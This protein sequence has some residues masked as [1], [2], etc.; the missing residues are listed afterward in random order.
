MAISEALAAAGRPAKTTNVA[1]LP[2]P[3]T[4]RW[5][6]RN[7]N[8]RSASAQFKQVGHP[9]ERQVFSERQGNLAA[10]V[11]AGLQ[12]R[13][14]P[15]VSMNP[16]HRTVLFKRSRKRAVRNTNRQPEDAHLHCTP[17]AVND[18]AASTFNNE[19]SAVKN[20]G[21]RAV[22]YKCNHLY[23]T[24]LERA[25]RDDILDINDGA[26]GITEVFRG[27]RSSNG[28]SM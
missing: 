28:V 13:A 17:L 2:A 9:L 11:F 4:E 15:P 5:A 3:K 23:M 21:G 22:R 20:T 14:A 7:D 12:F 24:H 16:L 8:E 19:V 25:K 26:E 1:N 6:P 18:N 10:Q 27:V